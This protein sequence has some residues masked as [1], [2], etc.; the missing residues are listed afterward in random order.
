M[1]EGDAVVAPSGFAVV[2]H[3][4]HQRRM[5]DRAVVALV[6]VVKNRLPVCCHGNLV[7]LDPHEIVDLRRGRGEVVEETAGLVAERERLGVQVGKHE[8]GEG[9]HS[10]RLQVGVLW[11]P[12]GECRAASRAPERPVDAIRPLMVR[13]DDRPAVFPVPSSNGWAR[14]L[15]TL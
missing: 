12:V 7:A 15:H 2:I 4:L 1:R 8:P 10:D 6:V 9:F 14:W 13:A 3:D 11:N 5:V